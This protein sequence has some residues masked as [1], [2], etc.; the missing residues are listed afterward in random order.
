MPAKKWTLETVEEVAKLYKTRK[1]IPRFAQ[2]RVP[3]H[4]LFEVT[5]AIWHDIGSEARAEEKRLLT[6]GKTRG[7]AYQGDPFLDTGNTELFY[8]PLM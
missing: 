3:N 6:I 1:E 4:I 2:G 5:H 8:S 7:D